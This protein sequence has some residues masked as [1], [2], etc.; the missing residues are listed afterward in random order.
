L[1]Q[2]FFFNISKI[3][4]F[5]FVKFISPKKRCDNFFFTPVFHA[6]FGSGIQDPGSRIWDPRSG[7]GKSRILDKHPGS[8][9]LQESKT[10]LI[11]K[12]Y[13]VKEVSRSFYRFHTQ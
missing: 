13:L 3:K 6:V 10:I 5:N 9:T 12:Q 8:A 7:M 11:E 2:I 4:Q 1:A